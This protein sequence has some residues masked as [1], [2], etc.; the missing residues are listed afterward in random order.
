MRQHVFKLLLK[1]L[2]SIVVTVIGAYVVRH[3]ALEGARTSAPLSFVGPVV[4]GVGGIFDGTAQGN[5]AAST[6]SSDV[7]SSVGSA[8]TDGN[9]E[10]DGSDQKSAVPNIAR[11]AETILEPGD[12][13]RV[14]RDKRTAKKTKAG[15]TRLASVNADQLAPHR[16]FAGQ[17]AMIVSHRVATEAQKTMAEDDIAPRSFETEE[18]P[19]A[20]KA[21]RSVAGSLLRLPDPFLV[22]A[23]EYEQPHTS[24]DRI[25]IL[26]RLIR[27]R[28]VE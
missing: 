27:A 24:L 20:A 25:R 10:I 8:P 22:G 5:G 23:R 14:L 6:G 7:I 13:K 2:V 26:S 17:S 28:L 9:R 16:A 3:D 12:H 19:L 15:A 4:N 11:S 21:F 18:A 1:C